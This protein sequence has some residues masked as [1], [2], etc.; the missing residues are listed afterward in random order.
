MAGVPLME[1]GAA[2]GWAV[3]LASRWE[4]LAGIP[5]VILGGWQVRGTAWTSGSR[6]C[7]GR[8]RWR[9][10][11]VPVSRWRTVCGRRF[12]PLRSRRSWGLRPEMLRWSAALRCCGGQRRL[13]RHPRQPPKPRH[14]PARLRRSGDIPGQ[15]HHHRHALTDRPGAGDPVNSCDQRPPS[16]AVVERVQALDPGTQRLLLFILC[17]AVPGVVAAE[18]DALEAATS[19]PTR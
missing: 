16:Q 9:L 14:G 6:N 8:S 19:T 13:H 17:T 2:P 15:A 10:T 1:A 12:S 5:G 18:L 7:L 4:A 3:R 11:W